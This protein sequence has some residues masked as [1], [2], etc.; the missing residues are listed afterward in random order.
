MLTLPDTI[1]RRIITCIGYPVLTE[2]DFKVTSTDIKELFILPAI[3]DMYFKR[4][5]LKEHSSYEVTTTF[6]IPFPDDDTW[7]VLNVSLNTAA[8]STA[9]KSGNPLINEINIKQSGGAGVGVWGTENDYGMTQAL[10]DQR[11]YQGSN[12]A[13]YQAFKKII[14]YPNRKITGYTNTM[15][16]ISITW[17]KYSEDWANVDYRFQ[18]DVI[19]LAQS[20]ILQY[21]GDLRNQMNTNMPDEVN[22]DAFVDRADELYKRV[23]EKWAKYPK[24]S[25]VRK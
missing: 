23:T 1:Y 4:F 14:D 21:F 22:G 25:I 11:S 15:G 20:Y 2:A 8:F 10:Y 9:Q 17:A 16:T 18:E 12:K 6:D 7:G 3:K 5:P 24:I 13:T 19:Q